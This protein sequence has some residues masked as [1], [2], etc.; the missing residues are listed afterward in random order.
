MPLSN[1]QS[2]RV[3]G[4]NLNALSLES[5]ELAKLGEN[6]VVHTADFGRQQQPQGLLARITGKFIGRR[7]P[8]TR[9]PL[10]FTSS[11]ILLIDIQ[12]SLQR[13]S[14]SVVDRRDL[15]FVL[16]VLGDYL[17]RKSARQFTIH[18]SRDSVKLTYDEREEI[19]SSE[20]L[21]DYGIRMYL[22]RAH[23]G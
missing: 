12:R 23:R 9:Y 15:S 1:A 8:E 7:E 14:G 21:Y 20:N 2:L 11:E 19:F 13:T 6:Y 16:R 18:W 4:Q 17:D 22:R 10:S 5:F 3:I